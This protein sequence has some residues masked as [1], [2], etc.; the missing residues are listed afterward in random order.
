MADALSRMCVDEYEE[1]VKEAAINAF[2]GS[3]KSRKRKRNEIEKVQIPS[4]KY[5]LIGRFHNSVV[6]HRGIDTTYKLMKEKKH[7]WDDM[8]L[9]IEAFIKKCPICQKNSDKKNDNTLKP[10]T[11][12]STK[13][14]HRIAVDTIVNIGSDKEGYKHLIVIID[15]F[16]RHVELYKCKDLTTTSAVEALVDWVCRFGAPAEIVSDNGSQYVAEL[17]KELIKFLN[18]GHLPIQPYSHEENGIV[19]RANKEVMRHIR[20]IIT[21]IKERSKWTEYIPLVKRIINSSIHSATGFRPS[22]M[23]YGDLIDLNRSLLPSNE[24]EENKNII[25]RRNDEICKAAA[26]SQKALDAE[27]KAERNPKKFTEF[28]VGDFV[29]AIPKAG[30]ESKLH[31]RRLGPYKVVERRGNVYICQNCITNKQIDYHV[32]WLF[33]FIWDK[34]NIDP[35]KVAMMDDAMYEVLKVVEHKFI[36]KKKTK[37]NLELLMQF[38]D[39]PEPKWYGWNSSY[40]D[41][42]MIQQYFR[43]NG[44]KHF[45]LER[46]IGFL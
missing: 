3:S 13:L 36:R 22:E 40:N 6:G 46:Y 39:D 10:F 7:S 16:S 9:H 23:L 37:D 1:G 43:D 32:K 34:V 21:E 5:K 12:A 35:E 19:E 27:H 8:K 18:I 20:N 14:M 33:P 17:I 45:I 44:L 25:Q 15:T 4:Q 38:D 11:L 42:P 24:N 26:K 2:K 30:P 29:L 31:P 28:K 41:V